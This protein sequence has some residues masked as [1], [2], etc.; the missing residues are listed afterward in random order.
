MLFL[1]LA[2]SGQIRDIVD[3][4]HYSIIIVLIQIWVWIIGVISGIAHQTFIA[5]FGFDMSFF[6]I[7]IEYI[8]VLCQRI[9]KVI[10][11]L[12]IFEWIAFVKWTVSQ[13]LIMPSYQNYQY[14]FR[15]SYRKSV[16]C[17]YFNPFTIGSYLVY[18]TERLVRT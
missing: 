7:G 18:G 14:L 17:R 4:L 10:I 8:T 11:G 2:Y 1:N 13:F 6:N 9:G 15:G 12:G 5:L 16:C 3:Y